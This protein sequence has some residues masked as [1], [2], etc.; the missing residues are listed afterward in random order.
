[1][2]IVSCNLPVGC[3]CTLNVDSV[4]MLVWVYYKMYIVQCMCVYITITCVLLCVADWETGKVY[5]FVRRDFCSALCVW[6]F[7]SIIVLW[8]LIFKHNGSVP[9]HRMKS[10]VVVISFFV[11]VYWSWYSDCDTTL[12]RCYKKRSQERSEIRPRGVR[13]P[14]YREHSVGEIALRNLYL[15]ER[16][17]VAL[18]SATSSTLIWHCRRTAALRSSLSATSPL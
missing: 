10:T 4:H 2:Q 13:H 16:D 12:C 11:H 14:A 8:S 1:M 18:R 6:G 5:R 15:S 9:T 7:V 17:R 3:F